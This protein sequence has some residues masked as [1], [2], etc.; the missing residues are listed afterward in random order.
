MDDLLPVQCHAVDLYTRHPTPEVTLITDLGTHSYGMIG[1]QT[2]PADVGPNHW[3]VVH[4]EGRHACI[5]I[6]S[7]TYVIPCLV[8]YA[9]TMGDEWRG[10]T[11]TAFHK[12]YKELPRPCHP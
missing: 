4:P 10:K 11:A 8:T 12:P 3:S 5:S 6:I 1:S 2:N 9:V 7:C